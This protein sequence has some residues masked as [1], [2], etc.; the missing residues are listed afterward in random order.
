MKDIELGNI[1]DPLEQADLKCD[2]VCLVY[3]TVNPKSFEYVARVYL[4]RAIA[5]NI[6]TF[7]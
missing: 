7:Y 4:V 2:V 6:S 5:I 3:D 1:L